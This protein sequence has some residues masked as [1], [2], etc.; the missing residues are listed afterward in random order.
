MF[1]CIQKDK[2]KKIIYDH[3]IGFNTQKKIMEYYKDYKP[4]APKDSYGNNDWMYWAQNNFH[5]VLKPG[6][7]SRIEYSNLLHSRTIRP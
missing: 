3:E 6:R 7:S 5:H 1:K 4:N 2:K